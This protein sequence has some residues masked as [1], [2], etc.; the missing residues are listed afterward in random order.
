MLVLVTLVTTTSN[1][2]YSPRQGWFD[3]R[4]RVHPATP[5]RREEL[6]GAPQQALSDP[7]THGPAHLHRQPRR[8]SH[9][10]NNMVH[11]PFTCLITVSPFFI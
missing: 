2:N 11:S 1:T 7:G 5:E 6:W 3:A 10:G 4:W 8:P 9:S